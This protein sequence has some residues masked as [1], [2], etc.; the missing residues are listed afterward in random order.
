MFRDFFTWWIAQLSDLVP[1]PW[2]RWGSMREDALVIEPVGSQCREVDSIGIT[3]RRH[4]RETLLGHFRLASDSLAELPRSPGNR[5]VLRL[6]QAD[7]L[8][9]TVTLPI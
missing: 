1:A 9:K 5:V 7:V 3:L 4:G 6:R 8:A 2:G